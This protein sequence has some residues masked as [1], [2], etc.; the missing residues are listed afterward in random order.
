M[1]LIVLLLGV[2]VTS[3]VM[4]VLMVRADGRGWRPPPVTR[5]GDDLHRTWP[6]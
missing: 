6:R 2:V 4:L 5:L 3:L 1:F